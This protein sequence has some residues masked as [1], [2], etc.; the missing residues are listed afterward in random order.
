MNGSKASGISS[1]LCTMKP[2]FEFTICIFK[3]FRWS[4]QPPMAYIKLDTTANP[5]VV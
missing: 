1:H 4:N 2:A 5:L 3:V